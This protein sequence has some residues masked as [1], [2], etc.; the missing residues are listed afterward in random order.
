[1][2]PAVMNGREA[3]RPPSQEVAPAVFSTR[4]LWNESEWSAI[5]REGAGALAHALLS[6]RMAAAE[7][8]GRFTRSSHLAPSRRARLCHPADRPFKNAPGPPGGHGRGLVLAARPCID[9][10]RCPVYHRAGSRGRRR[11][12]RGSVLRSPANGV[13]HQSHA[14]RLH[15]SQTDRIDWTSSINDCRTTPLHQQQQP[16]PLQ[17]LIGIPGIV[18]RIRSH[19]HLAQRNR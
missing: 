19:L 4:S 1:M 5:P 16:F 18:R 15:D 14:G 10:S 7:C 13:L 2:N 17:G 8:S 3:A 9:R 12:G 6:L 11:A